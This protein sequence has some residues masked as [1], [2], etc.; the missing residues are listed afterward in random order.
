MLRSKCSRLF[1]FPPQQ[2]LIL[3]LVLVN[4][5]VWSDERPFLDRLLQNN[6]TYPIVYRLRPPSRPAGVNPRCWPLIP[7]K[8]WFWEG[9][10]L[11]CDKFDRIVW[12][13]MYP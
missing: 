11:L 9:S 3:P 8:P 12:D 5:V 1:S 13:G 4:G 7:G 10:L 2:S 6:E